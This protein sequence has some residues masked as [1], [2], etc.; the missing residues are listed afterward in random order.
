MKTTHLWILALIISGFISQE[1]LAESTK[2][3]LAAK[4]IVEETTKAPTKEETIEYIN[5]SLSQMEFIESRDD[6]SF[7]FSTTSGTSKGKIRIDEH[8]NIEYEYSVEWVD[9]IKGRSSRGN[10]KIITYFMLKDLD[11]TGIR[12]KGSKKNNILI[13]DCIDSKQC[14]KYDRVGVMYRLNTL[15]HN[16]K[17]VKINYLAIRY[18]D[19][20]RKAEQLKK[21]YTHLINLYSK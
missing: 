4:R 2:N 16:Y 6:G 19:T 8:G 12:T 10:Y 13:I 1:L 7:E 15:K 5:N 9:K 18:I 20:T 3:P 21:A 14:I 17:D 11:E